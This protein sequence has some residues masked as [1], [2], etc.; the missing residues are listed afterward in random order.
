MESLELKIQQQPQQQ[1]EGLLRQASCAC[2][3]VCTEPGPGELMIQRRLK[4]AEFGGSRRCVCVF[5][6]HGLI[7]I[8]FFLLILLSRVRHQLG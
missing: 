4:V 2:P 1:Q 3:F 6:C 8:P 5:N 7:G